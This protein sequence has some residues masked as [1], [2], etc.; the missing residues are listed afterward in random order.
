M[1]RPS[2]RLSLKSQRRLVWVGSLAVALV[3]TYWCFFSDGLPIIWGPSASAAEIAQGREL[4]EHEWAPNDPLAHGDG[5]GPVFNARSCAACH[6]QGGLGGGG[7]NEHNVTSFEIHARHDDPTFRTGI[8]HNFSVDAANRETP[9]GLHKLF[10]AVPGR[11]IVTGSPGC[12]TTTVIPDFD[13][14]RTEGIQTTA[15]FGAGWIDLISDRA[16]LRNARNRGLRN[17]AR[18]LQMKF[19]DIPV[20][21][22]RNVAGGIGK[23]GW[24]AQFATLK[25]FVAAACANELGLGTP[26]SEQAKP[27]TGPERTAAPDLDR[28]QF[29][30]LVAF[31]KTLPKPVEAVP[32][33]ATRQAAAVRGKEV[34]GTIGCAA[35]HVPD[36]GGV[37]GVYSDFL[38]YSL[39]DPPPPGGGSGYG[40]PPP[41]LNLPSRPESD[42]KPEEWKTPPLWGVADSAPYLHDGSAKTLRE[43]ILIHRGDA[44]AVSDR[45][46][47]LPTDDQAAVLAFLGTL[48]A[49]PD[50]PQLRDPTVTKLSRK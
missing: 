39:T 42:P 29:R 37:K 45:Y 47:A 50:A 35:C 41:Q 19:D 8:I 26:M 28:K 21:R 33:D 17:V 9:G 30:A 22:V 44:R 31:V 49:P 2:P 46:Q 13:P 6:F 11:T 16:I 23:F 32:D 48:K 27:L 43:A 40:V 34:F 7:S 36:L 1:R 10:P 12:Q 24:K 5:L 38:L 14:V 20:G 18:E 3:V 15:L 4:F 25:E